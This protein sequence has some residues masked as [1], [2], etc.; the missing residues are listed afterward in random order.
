MH[1]LI[2]VDASHSLVLSNIGGTNSIVRRL[3]GELPTDKKALLL[4]INGH[5]SELKFISSNCSYKSFSGM[6]SFLRYVVKEDKSFVI[7]IYLYPY[8]RLIYGLF[9]S[10]YRNHRFGKLYC[11]WPDSKI[12]KFLSFADSIF[13]KYTGPV[14]CLTNRQKDYLESFLVKTAVQMWPPI[15]QNYFLTPVDNDN[16]KKITIT[17]VGR[18]DKGKGA[19]LAF[20]IL[21]DFIG[22]TNY[23]LKVLAHTVNNKLSVPI[24]EFIKNQINCEVHEVSYSGFTASLDEHVSK[25][26]KS[27]T[28]FI[29]PYRLLSSTIDCPMLIQE[30]AAA[31]CIIVSKNYPIIADIVGGDKYLIPS[32]L[33]DKDIV[34]ACLSKV[35]LAIK[36]IQNEK[37]RMMSH[38]QTLNFSS[39]EVSKHFLKNI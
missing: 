2:F 20:D 36:D 21:E 4:D 5:D 3:L 14:F 28:I 18:L 22:D 19:D 11:S 29:C 24:P 15:P 1:N 16:S 30:A 39:K 12:K 34:S 13:F 27:T 38:V 32:E 25:L 17:W 9:R 26:L 10:I 31:N 35:H 23:E 33:D 7:D 37:C 8:Q 6:F